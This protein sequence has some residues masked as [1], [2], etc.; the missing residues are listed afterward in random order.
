MFSAMIVDD[1]MYAV[2]GVR[3]GIDWA[4]LHVTE[5]YE[6]FNMRDAIQIFETRSIDLL[7]CDI[8]MPKGS[9]FD[10]VE[11][12]KRHSRDTE[13]IFLTCH[14]DFSFAK[15][16]IQL[17]SFDY[18]LKPVD[19]Q[20]LHAT[21]A[22]VLENIKQDREIKL[23]NEKFNEMWKRKRTVIN[24]RFWQDLFSLRIACYKENVHR[25]LDEYDLR[26]EA[27]CP[28]RIVLISIE[29]WGREW[30]ARDEELMEYALRNAAAEVVLGHGPGE[31]IQTH[32]GE[33]VVILYDWPE[34]QWE[35]EP[36][37]ERC[38]RLIEACGSYFGC[39]V[40][41]YLSDHTDIPTAHQT[42]KDLLE[43]EFSNLHKA[44]TV[45]TLEKAGSHPAEL[46]LPSFSIWAI[47]LEEGKKPELEK[48]LTDYFHALSQEK[49]PV[50]PILQAFF[51]G[52]LQMIHY[53]LH[54]QGISA[55]GLFRGDD[56][57]K[58]SFRVQS[59]VQMQ[60]WALNLASIVMD[61]I[62]H[63]DTDNVIDRLKRYIADHLDEPITREDLVNLVFLNPAYLSRLFKK[64]TGESISD[65][66]LLERMKRAKALLEHS[67]MTVSDIAKSLGYHNFSH[68]TKMFRKVYDTNPQSYRQHSANL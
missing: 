24:E 50:S 13:V 59:I 19:F 42:F 36:L 68:F 34:Q 40:S 64:E 2:Q 37:L 21:V 16:A 46:K 61:K 60:A 63:N 56:Y 52:Y 67:S 5:L 31:V 49:A 15:R 6:S 26:I 14:A 53:F 12:V 58:I 47:L 41:C 23:L 10:L 11:W 54:K 4:S 29:D 8:E 62:V 43:M 65:Y 66:I 38:N 1:E 55:Y 25:L 51:H 39:K 3:N 35:K 9:G 32:N 45:Y 57:G 20:V 18:L 28:I 27:E 48:Q 44:T 7:I 30:S 33:N 22:Q 17:E